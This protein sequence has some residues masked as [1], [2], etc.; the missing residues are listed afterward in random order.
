MRVK[1]QILDFGRTIAALKAASFFFSQIFG[2][3]HVTFAPNWLRQ[4]KPTALPAFLHAHFQG[5]CG[6][7][8]VCVRV[9][10]TRTG[11]TESCRGRGKTNLQHAAGK[12]SGSRVKSAPKLN[13]LE[14]GGTTSWQN[15]L[16]GVFFSCLQGTKIFFCLLPHPPPCRPCIFFLIVL[17]N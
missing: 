1:F 12:V 15:C 10:R 6:E 2:F 8:C 5:W 17:P 13:P 9:G 14:A 16:F 11:C 3:V 7:S 4:N